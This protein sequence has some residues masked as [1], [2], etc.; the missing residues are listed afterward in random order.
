METVT[1]EFDSFIKDQISTLKTNMYLLKKQ[2]KDAEEDGI[3][4]KRTV[5][6]NLIEALIKRF[7][8]NEKK[9]DEINTKIDSFHLQLTR[10]IEDFDRARAQESVESELAKTI[11]KISGEEIK[12][13]LKPLYELRKI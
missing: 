12:V 3:R 1:D 11:S 7:E 10:I 13:S 4:F 5:A 8:N 6:N 9:I 2:L